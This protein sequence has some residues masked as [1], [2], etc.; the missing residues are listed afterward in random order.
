MNCGKVRMEDDVYGEGE[1]RRKKTK[2]IKK[3]RK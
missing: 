1:K 2:K 3:K